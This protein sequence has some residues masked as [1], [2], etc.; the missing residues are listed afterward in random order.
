MQ[1][2]LVNENVIAA[3]S[4]LA[5]YSVLYVSKCTY[6]QT[7]NMSQRHVVATLIQFLGCTVLSR[8]R[9][10]G[11]TLIRIDTFLDFH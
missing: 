11:C 5:R 7:L 8:V 6:R 1:V 9:F 4:P 2:D 3:H 10:S